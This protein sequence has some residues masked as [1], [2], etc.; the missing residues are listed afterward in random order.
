MTCL[1]RA[2]VPWTAFPEDLRVIVPRAEL[3]LFPH[4]IVTHAEPP[5]DG[6][7]YD[8]RRGMGE[9]VCDFLGHVLD[10][11]HRVVGEGFGQIGVPLHAREQLDVTHRRDERALVFRWKRAIDPIEQSG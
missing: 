5:A 2:V 7:L 1:V 8:R 4:E 6:A 11:E 3:L 10:V 9:A